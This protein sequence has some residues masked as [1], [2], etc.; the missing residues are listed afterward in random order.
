MDGG[1]DRR[2]WKTENQE[3]EKESRAEQSGDP[4]ALMSCKDPQT[5]PKR[6]K[7]GSGLTEDGSMPVP[8]P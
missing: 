2:T 6:R 8:L 3:E 1:C 5:H 4:F 7:R